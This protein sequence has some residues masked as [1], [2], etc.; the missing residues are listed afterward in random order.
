[1]PNRY[2][3]NGAIYITT[4]AGLM[5]SKSRLNGNVG[6]YTMPKNRSFEIDSFEDLEFIDRYLAYEEPSVIVHYPGK[7]E[8]NLL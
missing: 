3:E 6:L 8:V 1:M 5:D 2:R 4:R 7:R